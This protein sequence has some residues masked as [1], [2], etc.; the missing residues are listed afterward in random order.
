LPPEE[1]VQRTRPASV[2]DGV[3][4]WE[5]ST[6]HQHKEHQD[7]PE[8]GERGA[9]LT[10]AVKKTTTAM[11]ARNPMILVGSPGTHAVS[12]RCVWPRWNASDK[13]SGGVSAFRLFLAFIAVVGFFTRE[14]RSI[15]SLER[16]GDQPH[17]FSTDHFDAFPNYRR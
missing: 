9:V 6:G 12:V 7:E 15:K 1:K 3:R 10:L 16:T 13:D 2:A 17:D 14:V 5:S 4:F 11:K 8:V